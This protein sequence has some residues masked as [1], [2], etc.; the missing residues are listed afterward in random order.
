M[1][2]RQATFDDFLGIKAV[3]EDVLQNDIHNLTPYLEEIT[4]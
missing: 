1:K 2:I 4:D 3:Y